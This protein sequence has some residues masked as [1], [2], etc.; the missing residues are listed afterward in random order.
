MLT[1]QGFNI[2]TALQNQP[3]PLQADTWVMT[4]AIEFSLW[5]LT[6]SSI[7]PWLASAS[8]WPLASSATPATD[9]GLPL[10][11]ITSESSQFLNSLF[12][13]AFLDNRNSSFSMNR[14]RWCLPSILYPANTIASRS[15][16]IWPA[17]AKVISA[18]LNLCFKGIYTDAFKCIFCF[19]VFTINTITPISALWLLP[20]PGFLIK[21]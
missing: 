20:L 3:Q 11:E 14:V 15:K 19:G 17:R 7:K 21:E 6:L 8:I 5:I 10:N 4:H 12:L 18:S 1:Q 9:F 16:L 2:D 13:K